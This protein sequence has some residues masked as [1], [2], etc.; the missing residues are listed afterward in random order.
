MDTP[1][2][3]GS[4]MDICLSQVVS[5]ILVSRLVR[6]GESQAQSC[7]LIDG[8]TSVFAAHSTNGCKPCE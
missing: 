1:E 6:D 3:T 4:D 5:G 7:V 2:S 8:A